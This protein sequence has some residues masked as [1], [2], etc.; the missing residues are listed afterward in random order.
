MAHPRRHEETARVVIRRKQVAN[1]YLQGGL[2]HHQIAEKLGVS[3]PTITMDLKAIMDQWRAEARADIGEVTGRELAKLDIMEAEAWAAWERSKN[4]AVSTTKEK[5]VGDKQST[6][7]SERREGRDGDPRY[8]TII[9]GCMERRAKLLGLD[10]PT[11]IAQTDP[12]GDP[13][14][15]PLVVNVEAM[16]TEQLKSLVS[17]EKFFRPAEADPSISDQSAAAS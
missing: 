2:L 4:E 8:M 5:I 17:L 13:A 3:R 7:A 1:L 12:N 6:K 16:T 11:K 10:A 9:I 15:A 14:H